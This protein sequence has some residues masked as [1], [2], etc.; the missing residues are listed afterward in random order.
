M[1]VADAAPEA[2][3]EADPQGTYVHLRLAPVP[4]DAPEPARPGPTA[5]ILLCDRSRS[6]LEAR[7]LQAR[8]AS[9]LLERLGPDDAFT[10]VDGDV[11]A[12][13]LQGGLRPATELDR[14]TALAF[15]DGDEPDGASDLGRL[16]VAGGE[17]VRQA[18]ARRLDPV[19]VYLGDASPTWGD[20]QAAALG[21]VAAE[22]LGGAALH[23]V[24]LGKSTEE[25]V[26]SALAEAGHGRL[27]RPKSED[28]AA[29]AAA[30]VASASGTRRIDGVRLLG[31]EAADVAQPP[32]STVY[33]GD[34][35]EASLFLPAG[36]DAR[37]LRLAGMVAGKPFSRPIELASA[38]PA[39]DVALRWAS[40]KIETLERDGDA[41]KDQVI[42]MSLSRGVMSRYTSLL[43]LESDEAY[44][45]MQITRK[46][47]TADPAEVRVSARDLDGADGASPSVSPDHLQPGDPE[48][49]VPAPAD[50]QSV[51]VVFPFG[52]TKEAS[53]E[54]DDRGG[55][56]VVRFL[57]DRRTPDGAYEILVRVTHH[58][59]T[60]EILKL[61]YVVDT[62]RPHLRVAVHRQGA[63]YKILATQEL[64]PEEIAA[65]APELTGTLDE[66]RRRAA[67]ILTDAKRVEVRAPDGQVLSLTHVRL[68]EFSGTWSPRAAG[69]GACP[70]RP[71]GLAPRR[72]RR[73]RAQR[74]R[75][76]RGAAM[77]LARA[78]GCIVAFA[79]IAGRAGAAPAEAAPRAD[80]APAE[81]KGAPALT[82]R[83]DALACAPLEGGALAIGTGGG[84]VLVGPAG[85]VRAITAM[86][87]LPG[88]RVYAVA[89]S[90]GSLWVGSE[91]GAA[92]VSL[93]PEL[94]V[95]RVVRVS[96]ASGAAVRA[97]LPRADG[98]YLGTWGAGVVR[99]APGSA[100]AE[101]VRGHASG[102]HVAA[103][104][105]HQ[106]SVYVAY[107]DGPPAVLRGGALRELGVATRDAA[108]ST[109]THGQALVSVGSTLLLGD[110]EG[111]FRLDGDA[112]TLVS[113]VDARALAYGP[114]GLLVGTF[115]AGLLAG[116]TVGALSP[117]RGVSRF[118]RGAGG[119]GSAR[120]VA[121]P[122]GVLVDEGS[123]WRRVRLGALPSNDVTAVVVSGDRVA[124]GTFDRGAT[125]DQ[126]GSLHPVA[127]LEP[128]E[129]IETAA[130]LGDDASSPLLLGTAHGLVRVAADGC[131]PPMARRGRPALVVRAGNP[132]AAGRSRPRR[133]RRRARVRRRGVR[134]R[135][136]ALAAPRR[137]QG[138]GAAPARV[139]DARHVGARSQ[140]RRHALDR[141]DGRPL[142][143]A[144][145]GV[146][147]RRPRHGRAHRRLGHRARRRRRGRLRRHL[148][149]R[150][151]APS[152]RGRRAPRDSHLGGGYVNAGGLTVLGDRLYAATMDGALVRAKDSDA[153][154][155]TRSSAR[156]RGGTSPASAR[157]ATRC[158]SRAGGE[159]AS[160]GG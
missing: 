13:A 133:D 76:G 39:R 144:G 89:P 94:R 131:N 72:R 35:V 160:R 71:G 98:V 65:Q 83:D 15:L 110:L 42:A 48:V 44:E 1:K 67:R 41:N 155:G 156:R 50:A 128:D 26:A 78:I 37:G 6:M 43:V 4:P 28:E 127:G 47:H 130:W 64:S 86:D 111:L 60:V 108:L 14:R 68:G 102:S 77:N 137:R 106:G 101:P 7:A 57:V 113:S 61:P 74:V 97:V 153:A 49:R 159:S 126:G 100:V 69:R 36:A 146:P 158:G 17:A 90:G 122:D 136:G 143:R 16:L 9:Q 32:P 20:T 79:L 152:R 151:D 120:C 112:A 22:S 34:E 45:R 88:T 125:I 33:E 73:P 21:R 53:F 52:E 24:L 11:S 27:L 145:D 30:L 62:Q 38:V 107:G 8:V 124:I 46:A 56:W 99:V 29:R 93:T 19:V 75:D 121:T 18:R 149:R 85:D 139:S 5:M 117:E 138:R 142:L 10:I 25:G 2:V 92:E 63:A 87:G 95:E 81:A 119:L 59:G 104:A 58:D 70:W 82:D 140:R 54:P 80:A 114:R 116:A 84:L 66:R 150:R 3:A 118:V 103:L 123:G 154:R 132:P 31:A 148:L 157:S 12:R 96:G 134:S 55:E 109:P 91:G 51:V 129:A 147:S 40:A 135:D 115:G 23:V 105:E 141:H